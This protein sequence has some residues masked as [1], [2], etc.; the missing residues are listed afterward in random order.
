MA[1][2]SSSGG[3]FA[4]LF[5]A[6]FGSNDKDAEKKRKLKSIAKKLS[7]THYNFYKAGS[8]EVL[9]A[10]AKF[11]YEIY[12]AIAPAQGVFANMQN[13]AAIKKAVMEYS[14]TQKQQQI[15]E[16]LTEESL[17]QKS[18]SF[19]L[20][21][22]DSFVNQSLV[23][24]EHEFTHE[25]VM[26]IESLYLSFLC[27]KEFCSYDFYFLLKKFDRNLSEKQFSAN[28]VFEKVAGEY[29]VDNVKDLIAVIWNVTNKTDWAPLMNF[30]KEV[31]GVE[32][33]ASGVW[34]KIVARLQSLRLSNA[35]EMMVQLISQNPNYAPD[36]S[37]PEARI[38]DAYF[39][40]Y[41]LETKAVVRKLE[42]AA[43]N[44]KVNDGLSKLFGKQSVTYL[45]YYTEEAS[46]PLEK[47]HLHG[48]MYALPLGYLKA[49]L[50]EVLKKE[51]R[52][53]VELVLVRGKWV[54]AELSS[55]MSNAYNDLLSVSD[56]ITEFDT[57]MAE[58]GKVGIKIKT[59]L[60]RTSHDKDASAV[61]NRLVNDSNNEA[62]QY[63]MVSMRNLI[64]VGKTIK[65][66]ID[67]HQKK[68]PEMIINW[69]EVEHA[70][71]ENLYKLG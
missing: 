58:D 5:G 32:P 55:P 20:Q 38:V 15:M 7:K 27:L 10:F 6:L 61:I 11:F 39:E 29:I 35:L 37:L 22:L 50:I 59:L 30:F 18:K 60:P 68:A 8:N 24:F 33:V 71:D 4:N 13:Q 41:K 63:I 26:R 69:K 1:Q 52:E 49:F 45:K 44:S 62:R 17:V 57:A 42:S 66:L 14:L 3:F 2:K 12:K 51:I 67:D 9:P 47:K 53:Y 31:R 34:K 70:S 28:P 65:A 64:T 23:A 25:L 19:S 40:K 48:Y 46:S 36:V 56:S 54:T 16:N 43:K 21:Q